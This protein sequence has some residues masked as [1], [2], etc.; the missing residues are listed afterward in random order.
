M[1]I[2]SNINKTAAAR[3]KGAFLTPGTY[4]ATVVSCRH[5]RS[6][7][8]T[9]EFFVVDFDLVESTNPEL[10]AGSPVTWMSKLTGRYPDMALADVKAFVMAGTGAGEADVTEDTLEE[11]LEGDGTELAGQ[12]VKIVCSEVKTKTGGAFTKH[13]YYSVQ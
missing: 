3:S 12:R 8:G 6:K 11:V 1:G 9:D 7:L 13:S 4:V 10:P 5:V 2:F